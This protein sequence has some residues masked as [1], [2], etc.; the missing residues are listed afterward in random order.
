MWFCNP[1]EPSL[2]TTLPFLYLLVAFYRSLQ[3]LGSPRQVHDDPVLRRWVGMW[4]VHTS[5]P[6]S[7][8]ADLWLV[9]PS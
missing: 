8:L 7:S 9:N 2:D 6:S 3:N 1:N 5:F 4:L